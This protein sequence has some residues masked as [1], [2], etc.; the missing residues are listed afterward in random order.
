M[1]NILKKHSMLNC[2]AV[3]HIFSSVCT[4][5]TCIKISAPHS[6]TPHTHTTQTRTH[7]PTFT[8][9]PLVNTCI[10]IYT[11][12]SILYIFHLQ[13]SCESQLIQMHNKLTEQVLKN[14]LFDCYNYHLNGTLKQIVCLN[15]TLC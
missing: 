15:N 6:H 3:C 8:Y 10:Y 5:L 1:L 4:L 12:R 11:Y 7:I 14:Q 9:V 13:D 2:Y